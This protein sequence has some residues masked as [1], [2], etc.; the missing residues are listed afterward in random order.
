MSKNRVASNKNKKVWESNLVRFEKAK[1]SRKC[2]T[3]VKS[4]SEMN[5][6]PTEQRIIDRFKSL[7]SNVKS[8]KERIAIVAEET[9]LLWRK[10]NIPIQQGKSAAERKIENVLKKLDK[11][12]RKPGTQNFTRLFDITDE[13]GEWLCQEDKEFYCLQKSTNGRAGYC[14]TIKD[15]EGIHPRKLVLIKK[16]MS[17][18]QGQD[19]VESASEGEPS[20]SEEQCSSSVIEAEGPSSSSKKQKTNSAVNLVISAKIS[21]KK[22]H[23][24]CKTLSESGIP[25]HTPTQSGIYKGVMKEGEKLKANF[26]E[27]LKNEK[28]SLH[29]DGKQIKKMEHQVVVLKN[30]NREVRLAVLEMMNGKSETIYNGIKH[31]L[32][33]YELWPSIKMIVSDTTSTNTG[34]RNG[35]VTRLQKHFKIIGLEKP[36]F[37]GCQHHIL[38]TLLKHV[39]NDLFEGSTMSPYLHYPFVT[40]L[41]QDYENLKLLFSNIG[42]PLTKVKRTRWRDDMDF[43]NHLIACYRKFKSTGNF[44]KVNFKSLPAISNARWNSRAIFILLAYI[45]VPEYQESESAQ[46]ACDFICGSWGD[47]WFGGNYFNPADFV[48]LLEACNEH[49]KALK[50]LKRFWSTEPTPIPTQRSNICAERAVKVMQDLMPLCH[51]IEKLNIKYLLSNTQ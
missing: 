29:F 9:K 50:S 21:T 38:D 14:T 45:L 44:P 41:Q 48:N 26:M 18:S 36:V 16:Q 17:I 46:A 33:E 28:W 43:L 42:N 2:T 35:V 5:K 3:V 32:D 25:I 27:N 22:A 37:I 24:V 13:K 31:V 40:R 12:S 34:L 8:R 11:D 4:I 7:S 30:E 15:A 1:T 19:F 51:S 39:M 23:K 47:I 20:E 6:M 10:L 49:P